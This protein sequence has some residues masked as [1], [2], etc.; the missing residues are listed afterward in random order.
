MVRPRRVLKPLIN[1]R[2]LLFVLSLLGLTLAGQARAFNYV[3]DADGTWWGIQDAA[4]PDV[5]TGS[6][7]A[8]QVGP[9]QP[10][11]FSTTINGFGGIKVL[12]QTDHERRHDEHEPRLAHE[13]RFNGE[14]MRGFGLAFDGVNRFATTQSIDLGGVTIS[15][16]V[17]INNG[18]N[19]GRW[20]D[21]FTNSTNSPLTI[22]V[23]FGGQ[24]GI[25]ASGTGSSAI[26]NT[27]SG[28][29]VV[30]AA[31]A[32]VDV[33]TPLAG[34]R[35]VGG[36]QVTVMGTPSTPASPFK[37]AITFAGNWLVDT[38]NNPI[39]YVGHAGNFQGYV[40]TITLR[41]GATRSLL[42]FVVLGQMVN[43]ASSAG[44]QAA[45]EATA[46]ELAAAPEIGDLTLAEICSIDNFDVAALTAHGFNYA[47][48][49]P[50]NRNR[51]S[52]EVAQAPVPQEKKAG[53]SVR[54]DV[55]GKTIAQLRADMI[56]HVTTSEEITQAYLDRIAVYDTGQFG[57]H[58]YEIVASNAIEQARAADVA[59]RRGASGALLGIPIVVKNLFDTFDM[60]TTNGSMTFAGFRPVHDAFQIAR[61]RAAGAVIIGKG[62]LEEY[63]TS[64]NYSNDAFGQVW[65]V[66]NPSKSSIASSGGPASALAAS[67]AAGAMGSQTGD[68]LYG[69][70][71]AASLVTLRGT[72]GLESG[73]GV[74]PL[75]YLTDFGGAMARSVPDLADILNV[76]VAV[77]PADPETLAPG[78][79]TPADW[80][81]VLDPNA[82]KGKRIGFVASTWV[83]PFGT[84]NTTSA[85]MA[86]LQ[87]FVDAGAT[88]VPVGVAVGGTDAPPSPPSPTTDRVSEGWWLYI[89]SHPELVT[90]GFS[91][92]TPVDVSCSQK[93]VAYVRAAAG[94][95]LVAPSAPLTDAQ[96][97]TWRDYLRGRQATAKTWMDTAGADGKG[98]DA[99]VY[100][101]LL[102][103]ISLNDGGGNL[104]SFGRRDT[105]SASN[106]IPTVVF[107]V[108]FNDDGQ[109]I[110][111]QL[112]GRA[113]DDDKL[114]GMAYAFEEIA[115]AAGHGHVE[116][117]TAPPLPPDDHDHEH[118]RGGSAELL[119][120]LLEAPSHQIR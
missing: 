100:P 75:T 120:E 26:V 82:L 56:S 37:G 88:I 39:A 52:L 32:W 10:S 95:C 94:A 114:V 101:G 98:V 79:H 2:S 93:K 14:L 73:T 19:W 109:P 59:R 43:A 34:T 68:S 47:A 30:T 55:V 54:Y 106:G 77:D 51:K 11:G 24:S 86:A 40:N 64:G 71:S 4:S 50:T 42:H 87:Y 29:A 20:L 61:L 28:D 112:L 66:F 117:T 111:I 21:S 119:E 53:T 84:T 83:D 102:S 91:I 57:F 6:I 27:S 25:G 36:P 49:T 115:N 35:L 96:V 8:T 89:G 80:R 63:A 58:S 60:A 72:N 5:D 74:Q 23:A 90:E 76:V 48:C 103:D 108:G 16:S 81:S 9:G 45:V 118:E 107:P 105:P 65:N 31:D 113:W 62:A 38:F 46:S 1:A 3:D 7:R 99:V 78:R 85:E 104:A 22:K 92:H 44:V 17:Y 12:V 41:P 110:N 18:A 33:A 67:L 70:S 13:V 69:P 15:R 97:Q 116:A